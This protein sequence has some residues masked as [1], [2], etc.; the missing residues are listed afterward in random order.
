MTNTYFCSAFIE[1]IH[2]RDWHCRH[3]NEARLLSTSSDGKGSMRQQCHRCKLRH[4]RYREYVCKVRTVA[5]GIRSL[6]AVL[7]HS[8]RAVPV[9]IIPETCEVACGGLVVTL[10]ILKTVTAFGSI[11]LHRCDCGALPDGVIF[12]VLSAIFTGHRTIAISILMPR[13]Q[14]YSRQWQCDTQHCIVSWRFDTVRGISN[15]LAGM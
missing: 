12:R 1:W 13:G 15:V 7:K 3:Q 11:K 5:R 8:M 4:D 2:L 6:A 10:G 9:F 14:Y